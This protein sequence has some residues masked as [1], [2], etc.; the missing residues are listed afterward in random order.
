MKLGQ[1]TQQQGPN[2]TEKVAALVRDVL[3]DGRRIL[4]AQPL[5]VSPSPPAIAELVRRA[6]E[7]DPTYQP[8][9]FNAWFLVEVE[10]E[11]PSGRF[12]AAAQ[13]DQSN[14][15]GAAGP[16]LSTL[17]NQPEIET[18]HPLRLAPPPAII[19]PS[20]DPR[21]SNQGYL[22]AA[23]I[24]IDARYAWG[25]PGGDGAGVGF[26]DLERGWNL[27]H[28]DLIAAGVTLISG[29]SLDYFDHGTSV[30]GE[31]LMQDN[32][33]GGVGIAPGGKGRVVSQWQPNGYNT[34]GAILDAISKM[35]FGDVLLLEAQAYDPTGSTTSY[36][37]VEV[38]D[39]TFEAIR[40]ATALGI[41][42][43]EAGANGA[44]DLDTYVNG[45]GARI[46]ARSDPG[47][48]DSGAILVG[49]GSSQPTHERLYFS[50]YG[51]RIDVYAWGENVDTTTTNFEGT[52]NTQYTSY[53]SGTSSASPI[54]SGASMIVQGLMS[55]SRGR[56]FSP[57]ELRQ[58]LTQG[59]TPSS[60]PGVDRIGVL[61]N[62]K[63]II[64]A[65]FNNGT[66]GTLA[67]DVR[68]KPQ[69]VLLSPKATIQSGPSNSTQECKQRC[70]DIKPFYISHSSTLS[71]CKGFS[72]AYDSYGYNRYAPRT[73]ICTLYAVSP[74]G[75]VQKD[76][77]AKVSFFDVG[78]DV[79]QVKWPPGRGSGS[80]R[81]VRY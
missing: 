14:P 48:R 31:V 10:P 62:L 5:I 61:P 39:A 19:N 66:N 4:N 45:A 24:G 55:T 25:F 52:D 67:C 57:Q 3:P 41:T 11:A 18:V 27:Q 65:N 59:G 15:Q 40:L 74:Q 51:S 2:S 30:L 6:A 77:S 60:Q 22:D 13:A 73:G 44:Y 58:I 35:Q 78:C 36:L 17:N 71:T 54:I 23:P 64:Q 43:V 32:A 8:T 80:G 81:P 9:D 79:S 76:P 7:L 33:L 20:D 69:G 28:E 38:E 56:R 29:E 68:G 1:N 42:V 63:A 47:F 21:S 70:L 49:A 72:Y 26:V 75:N 34:P 16:L 37:P 53:F 12:T 46:F 50:N